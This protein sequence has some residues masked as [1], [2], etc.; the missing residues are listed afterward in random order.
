MRTEEPR[1]TLQVGFVTKDGWLIASERTQ[2]NEDGEIRASDTTVKLAASE[3]L[4]CAASGDGLALIAGE[5]L[6][7]HSSEIDPD[8]MRRSLGLFGDRIWDRYHAVIDPPF[9][10]KYN[11][12]LLIGFKTPRTPLWILNIGKN[13]S[14]ATPCPSYKLAGDQRNPA[15]FFLSYYSPSA[16][17]EELKVL[18]AHIITVGAGLNSAG[19][20]RGLDIAVC[21]NEEI[22]ILE[23]DDIQK[24]ERQSIRLSQQIADLFRKRGS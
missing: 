5:Q 6:V 9:L 22:K 17:L 24:L 10:E 18:A 8:D 12:A 23:P 15:A 19:V 2:V 13:T 14:F 4:A 1:V 21:E 7:E 20:G 11:R 16:S 3:K